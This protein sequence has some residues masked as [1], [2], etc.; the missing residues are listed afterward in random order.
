MLPFIS[1][2]ILEILGTLRSKSMLLPILLY[3]SI[4]Y[5]SLQSANVVAIKDEGYLF[6]AILGLT[7]ASGCFMT[8]F[9]DQQ[10]G[11]GIDICIACPATL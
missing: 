1:L 5:F 9:S 6:A 4:L 11:V 8:S 10:N 2:L 7:V 3:P